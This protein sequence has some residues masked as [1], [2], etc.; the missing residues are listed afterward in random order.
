MI[1]RSV[2]IKI[3]RNYRATSYT[4]KLGILKAETK[5]KLLISNCFTIFFTSHEI[6]DRGATHQ[7]IDCKGNII[8]MCESLNHHATESK[9]QALSKARGDDY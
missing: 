2:I 1:C 8:M 4:R 6:E 7:I 3:Y 5:I 9:L